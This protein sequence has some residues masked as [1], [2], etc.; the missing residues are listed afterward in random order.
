M[1]FSQAIDKRKSIRS[2]ENKPVPKALLRKLIKD[3]AKAPSSGNWQPWEFHVIVS[4]KIRDKVSRILNK[5]LA[6][7]RNEIS[8]LSGKLQ[9]VIHGFYGDLGGCQ[10]IIFV[11]MDKNENWS[12]RDSKIMSVS[13]AVENLMLS[14]VNNGLGTCWVGSFRVVQKDISSVLGICENKELVAGI[15]VGYP[16]KGYRP[17]RREKKKLN[18]ILTF[19]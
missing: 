9:K 1:E 12:N 17:L 15:L 3:A 16:K 19:I 6:K 7:E 13:A 8:K 18:Q 10:N 2:F 14:A 11:Y 5:V 4:G